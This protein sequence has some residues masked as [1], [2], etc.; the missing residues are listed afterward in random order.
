VENGKDE[1]GTISCVV[2]EEPDGFVSIIIADD[3]AGINIQR[4][5][6]KAIEN[7]LHTQEELDT[8]SDE[9]ICMLIFSDN[10]STKSEVSELSGRGIG[11][12]AVKSELER[13]GGYMKISTKSG[14][15]ATFAFYMPHIKK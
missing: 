8:M 7:G 5:S 9:E 11:L 6:Q 15:G 14:V 3:G 12:S 10:F 2:N 4:V 13:I 1:C